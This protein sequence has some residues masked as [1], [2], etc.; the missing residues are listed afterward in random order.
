MLTLEHN[1]LREEYE[2]VSNDLYASFF[3]STEVIDAYAEWL[4]K[5]LLS[6]LLQSKE[7]R[8][9]VIKFLARLQTQKER[10]ELSLDSQKLSESQKAA[11]SFAHKTELNP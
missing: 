3:T 10:L 7:Q 11:I 6:N 1:L 4:R 9:N 8:A 2:A 5:A